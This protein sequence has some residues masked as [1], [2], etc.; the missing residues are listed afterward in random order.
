MKELYGCTVLGLPKG[1]IAWE[2][3]TRDCRGIL[4]IPVLLYA[5]FFFREGGIVARETID[6]ASNI[7]CHHYILIILEIYISIKHYFAQLCSLGL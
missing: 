5:F 6:V 3:M 1:F 4:I 2:F 7:A